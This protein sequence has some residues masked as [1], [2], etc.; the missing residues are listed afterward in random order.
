MTSFTTKLMIAA[1]A[2]FT[3]SAVSAQTTQTLKAD[4]PFA[5][6]SGGKV[7]AAGTYQVRFG[8]P[9]GTVTI[10]DAQRNGVVMAMP[11]SHIERRD[12]TAKLVFACG[13]GPCA[14]VQAWPGAHGSGLLFKTPKRDRNE[15]A[16]LAVIHLR[17]DLA[18]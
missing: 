15:E 5:F 14:L 3:A 11:N 7:L 4:I 2:L 6:Q 8:G 18:D 13:H 1:A 12:A 16:T 9:A 17:L 10:I